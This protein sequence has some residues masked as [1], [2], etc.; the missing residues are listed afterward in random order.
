MHEK[1]LPQHSLELLTSLEHNSSPSL[2]NWTLAGGTG[3]AFLLGHRI[4]EDLD[5][6]RTDKL[7]LQNLHSVFSEYGKYETLQ[8]AEDTLTVLVQ[9]TKLSFFCVR[10]PFLFDTVPHRFFSIASVSDI[11]LMKL[12]AIS[13]RGSRKDFADL[14]LILQNGP[15]LEDYFDMLPRKYGSSRI[16]TYHILKS[17]TYFEDAEK[18]PMPRM[19]VPFDWEECKSFFIRQAR[20]IVLP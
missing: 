6:F 2:M 10:D 8:E 15:A 20:A 1:V 16:N 19:L 18:E 17:L 3:L 12:V 11:A 14:Y 9:N 5:F 4:S 13:G 7:D